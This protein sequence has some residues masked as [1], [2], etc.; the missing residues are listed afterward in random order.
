MQL[1]RKTLIII[2]AIVIILTILFGVLKVQDI[3]LKKIYPQE[4]REYVYIYSEKNGIDPLLTFA[5]MKAESNFKTNAYSSSGA[6]GL[7]QLMPS[8]A[9]EVAE[10]IEEEL[11]VKEALYNP[12]KNIM[13]GT[14]YFANLME[15][16]DDNM[17]LSLAAYNA[18]IGKVDE[19]I[20]KGVI[21]EDGSDIENI[22]YKETNH[23]VRKIVRD[24][25]IYKNLYKD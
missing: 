9:E 1:K 7:M 15:K 18:G 22:P 5:I 3:I 16:Y 4:Y 11:I 17:L 8:T 12:E 24:Y 23:Y 14:C 21:K 6:I 25:K 2:V 13:I 10:E 20:K 19:W